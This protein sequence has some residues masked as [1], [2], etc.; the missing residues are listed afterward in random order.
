LD[1]INSN[2]VSIVVASQ[3][4]TGGRVSPLLIARVIFQE[5]RND[6]N[7]LRGNDDSSISGFGGPEL[8]NLVAKGVFALGG[9]GSFGIGEMRTDTAARLLG[10][11]P[12]KLTKKEA[13][14]IRGLLGHSG[15]SIVLIALYLDELQRQAPGAPPENILT[16]YNSGT[17]S[18]S[19]TSVA[20]RSSQHLSEIER[21]LVDRTTVVRCNGSYR[22]VYQCE[23]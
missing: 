7:W 11:N 23:N 9:H 12:D 18:S 8:K 19:V 16:G 20:N 14:E 17:V 4:F 6:Y 13:A 1:L 3:R 2:A 21:A 15:S 22:F 10:Y 5:N